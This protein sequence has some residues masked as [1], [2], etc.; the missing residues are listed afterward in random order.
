M[1]VSISVP[2]AFARDARGRVA[3][4]LRRLLAL[5]VVGVTCVGLPPVAHA[6][7]PVYGHDL[8]NS[9]DAGSAGPSPS[10]VGLS[11]RPAWTFNAS[12]GDFTGTPVVAAGVLVAGNNGGFVYAL[13]AFSGKLLWSKDV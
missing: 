5:A 6:D 12:T 3:P 1:V 2:T 9:R 4:G 10:E 11:A 8:S 13:D 7:W